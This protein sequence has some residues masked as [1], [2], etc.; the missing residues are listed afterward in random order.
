MEKRYRTPEQ[1][2]EH[3]RCEKQSPCGTSMIAGWERLLVRGGRLVCHSF[4]WR[5]LLQ[6]NGVRRVF[7][8]HVPKLL[9]GVTNKTLYFH[10]AI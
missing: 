3:E 8:R 5:G 9:S 2:L 7:C 1:T 10:H 4:R 6:L